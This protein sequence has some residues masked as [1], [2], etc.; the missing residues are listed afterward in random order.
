MDPQAALVSLLQ[1]LEDASMDECPADLRRT[2]VEQLRHLADWLEIGGFL[3]DLDQA[4]ETLG[5]HD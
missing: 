2:V 5:Y 3:P 4:L 1:S